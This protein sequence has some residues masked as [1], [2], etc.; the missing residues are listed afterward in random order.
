MAKDKETIDLSKLA[1]ILVAKKRRFYIVWGITFIVSTFIIFSVPRYYS[2][3]VKLAPEMD[4]SMASGTLGSLAS[5][6]GF[7]L[8]DFQTSDAIS[9]LLYPDLMTDNGFVTSLF[10]TQVVSS[11]LQID[12]TYYAYLKN[13]QKIPWW[14]KITAFVMKL[15]KGSSSSSSTSGELDPYYLSKIDN[16]IANAIRANITFNVD[17]KTGVITITTKAQDPLICKT[18]ADTTQMHLQKYITE[19]RTKKARIDAEYY[20]LLTSQAKDE[21]NK[22]RLAYSSYT[23]ANQNAVL[24][25]V[26]SKIGDLENDMQLKFNNYT[27]YNAQLQA[28]YAKI[29]ERTPAFTI[30]KGAEVPT[31]PAGPKRMIFVIAMMFLATFVTGVITS[32]HYLIHFL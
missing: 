13:Y 12:T 19:Y 14:S 15:L 25:S 23:D 28:A 16:D 3:S 22:A 1:K 31:R 29:Q 10:P 4:N 30:L 32:R 2:S 18:L 8:A 17:K 24:Q 27:A 7:D 5:S 20:S 21:Y 11:D 6:F 9:P 26:A